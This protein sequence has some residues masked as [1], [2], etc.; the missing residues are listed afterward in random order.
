MM[1]VARASGENRAV[2]AAQRAISSPLLEHHSI[3]GAR[4]L[5]INVSGGSDMSLYDVTEVASL[6]REEAHEDA[7]IIFGAVVD[8]RLT[9]EIRVTVIATGFGEH[10]HASEKPTSRCPPSDMSLTTSMRT[11]PTQPDGPQPQSANHLFNDDGKPVGHL[12][13]ESGHA[14]FDGCTNE[15][16]GDYHDR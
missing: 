12:A 1:G 13:E 3:N 5:L 6:V 16:D 10:A 14:L 8:E 15:R 11:T 4:G 7:N 9:D 2:E